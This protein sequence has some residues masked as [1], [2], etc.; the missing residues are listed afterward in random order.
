MAIHVIC[1]NGHELHVDEKYAGKR[2]RCPKCQGIVVIPHPGESSSEVADSSADDERL[3]KRAT[4]KCPSCERPLSKKAVLCVNCGFDLRTGTVFVKARRKSTNRS[5]ETKQ[6]TKNQ[7][8]TVVSTALFPIAMGGFG[9]CLLWYEAR[10]LLFFV[11]VEGVVTNSYIGSEWRS[12]SGSPMHFAGVHFRY[13]VN[14]NVYRSGQYKIRPFG[15]I[16]GSYESHRKTVVQYSAGTKVK[17][18]YDPKHPS[19]AVISRG[20][21][22]EVWVLMGFALVIAGCI[23]KMYR[24]F[25]GSPEGATRERPSSMY[26]FGQAVRDLVAKNRSQGG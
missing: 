19:T 13:E 15:M 7:W 16:G 3:S 23:G 18:W 8:V 24:G 9:L 26:R 4:K 17:G 2:G 12:G 5:S 14:G 11:P 20:I 22:W 21:G 10:P 25:R 6:L 1:P